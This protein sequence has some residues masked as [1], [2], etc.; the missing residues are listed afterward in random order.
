MKSYLFIG[1]D[2]SKATLDVSV[3]SSSVI[4]NIHYHQFSNSSK[5]FPQ[6]LKWVKQKSEGI[7]MED[8]RVCMENTVCIVWN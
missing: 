1:I 7:P 5:G 3:F 8:W 6:L 2:I 4:T